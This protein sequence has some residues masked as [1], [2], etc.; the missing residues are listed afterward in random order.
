M[1]QAVTALTGGTP[2]RGDAPV[3]ALP[4]PPTPTITEADAEETATRGPTVADVDP[5]EAAAARRALSRLVGL[6]ELRQVIRFTLS[7]PAAALAARQTPA[8]LMREMR[9]P[10]VVGLHGPAGLGKATLLR[11]EAEAAAPYVRLHWLTSEHDLEAADTALEAQQRAFSR[12]S[13]AVQ[14]AERE[15]PPT[16]LTVYVLD[17]ALTGRAYDCSR[18]LRRFVPR[19]TNAQLTPGSAWQGLRPRLFVLHDKFSPSDLTET[20]AGAVERWAYARPPGL[21]D[22]QRVVQ[23]ETE[24]VLD[25]LSSPGRITRLPLA[26]YGDLAR[27]WKWWTPAE[28]VAEVAH[29]AERAL[30][31]TDDPPVEWLATHLEHWPDHDGH[32][33]ER[34]E[35]FRTRFG[36]FEA[37][38]RKEGVP[39]DP[40]EAQPPPPRP[41]VHTRRRRSR[42]QSRSPSPKRGRYQENPV[43][44][45]EKEDEEESGINV[46]TINLPPPASRNE[47]TIDI[48]PSFSF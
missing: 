26:L 9:R 28:L 19:L 7:E 18:L 5:Q 23:D 2:H 12:Q 32:L 34:Q 20:L 21:P 33:A 17:S 47:S 37:R 48:E 30:Q 41:P 39:L 35:Q 1:G 31:Q 43:E 24:R 29:C 15:R 14:R 10:Q 42:P 4:A 25:A 36:P 46:G 3:L 38:Y 45:Q 44:P 16:A 8:A 40:P 6:S 22:R 11:R 13:S 27:T